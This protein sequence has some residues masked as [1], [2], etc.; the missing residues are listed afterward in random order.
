MVGSGQR[1][2]MPV[3]FTIAGSDRRLES[4]IEVGRNNRLCFSAPPGLRRVALYGPGVDL[5]A[6]LYRFELKFHVEQ[7]ADGAFT[8]ELCDLAA[9]RKHYV[10][11]CFDWELEAGCIRL[12]YPFDQAVENLEVRLIVPGGCVGSIGQLEI[13]RHPPALPAEAALAQKPPAQGAPTEAVPAGETLTGA[14]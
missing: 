1:E 4:E 13:S 11:P 3:L 10:R 12:S 6:G 14:I 2:Q 5:P 9:R 8:I 7:R